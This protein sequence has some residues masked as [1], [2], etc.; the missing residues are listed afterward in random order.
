LATP[1]ISQEPETVLQD[2][3]TRYL[4]RAREVI[5]KYGPNPHAQ[6]MLKRA[7][8]LA[9]QAEEQ[10]K[11]GQSLAGLSTLRVATEL[12][13]QAIRLATAGAQSAN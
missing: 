1:V 6:E 11:Q 4:A 7:E 9:N 3:R 10:I 5:E 12:T 2:F 8:D 13:L